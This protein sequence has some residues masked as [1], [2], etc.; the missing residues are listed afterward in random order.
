MFCPHPSPLSETEIFAGD[1]PK[2]HMRRRLRSH[3]TNQ[4]DDTPPRAQIAV[5]CIANINHA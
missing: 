1:I 5:R 4:G 2:P 3:P